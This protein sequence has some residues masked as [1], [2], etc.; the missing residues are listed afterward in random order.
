MIKTSLLNDV[1]LFSVQFFAIS[2]LP[3]FDKRGGW[4]KIFSS[5]TNSRFFD[6]QKNIQPFIDMRYLSLPPKW[7]MLMNNGLSG[8][9]D[10]EGPMPRP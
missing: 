9:K 4:G 2:Q 6:K 1:V 8:F 3:I 5:K 7:T 10:A